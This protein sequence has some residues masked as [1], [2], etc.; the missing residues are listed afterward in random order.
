MFS[1]R[2]ILTVVAILLLGSLLFARPAPVTVAQEEGPAASQ[3]I[4]SGAAVDPALAP[5]LIPGGPGFFSANGLG[6]SPY[7]SGTV[8]IAF[9][10]R[11]VYNPDTGYHAY[12][13]PVSLPHG[14]TI[15]KFVIWVTDNAPTD[16]WAAIGKMGQ[17]DSSV[18]QVAY[19]ASSGAAPGYRVFTDTTMVSPQ[20]DLQNY[21]Y[22]V[23][24]YLPPNSAAGL[25]SFRI[26][27][28]YASYAPVIERP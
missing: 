7:V 12:E 21:V 20:V 27:F 28:T 22:W 18:V 3:P 16:M 13:A 11:G 2:R 4:G 10:G 5:V 19:V 1:K 26:D 17:D 25:V 23:E 14:A 6:F 9:S 8:P 24:V 15:N